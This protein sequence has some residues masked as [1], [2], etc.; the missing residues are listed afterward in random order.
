MS[1]LLK[2]LWLLPGS[3]LCLGSIILSDGNRPVEVIHQYNNIKGF[4]T[5]LLATLINYLYF[6]VLV[7]TR[8]YIIMVT[9]YRT[10]L[11]ILDFTGSENRLFPGYLKPLFQTEANCG[12]IDMKMI[13]FPHA[14]K[15]K[16]IISTRRVLQLALY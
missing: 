9:M 4:Y 14:I 8:C 13:F 7:T 10:N 3:S 11:M 1:F 6:H 2:A 12:A 15:M 16:L 5:L